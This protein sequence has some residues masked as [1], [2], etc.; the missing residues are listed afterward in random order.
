MGA[1]KIGMTAEQHL[2]FGLEI[3]RF[4][5]S[6]LSRWMCGQLGKNYPK[7]HKA[8]KAVERLEKALSLL[9]YVMDDVA[10]SE[11][12]EHATHFYYGD[13]DV[14]IDYNAANEDAADHIQQH[15]KA[16]S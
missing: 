6:L 9:K 11:G 4:R 8:I 7:A 13:K 3:K 5:K 12:H 14:A 16:T 2:A 15:G 10:C 1:R